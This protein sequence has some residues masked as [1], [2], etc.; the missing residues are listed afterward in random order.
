MFQA[1]TV[2]RRMVLFSVTGRTFG[3]IPLGNIGLPVAPFG[4]DARIV[5]GSSDG[6]PCDKREDRQPWISRIQRLIGEDRHV[7]G[8]VVSERNSEHTDI[9][10][11]AI[12]GANHSI[13]RNLVGES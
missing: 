5:F 11:P 8:Y 6:G 4:A 1:S 3:E 7:L 10:R 12:S 2:G 9:V 13:F